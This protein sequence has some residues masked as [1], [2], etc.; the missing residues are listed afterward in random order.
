MR[1]MD[2]GRRKESRTFTERLLVLGLALS[3]QGRPLRPGPALGWA[4][5]TSPAPGI[6]T[7]EISEASGSL[8]KVLQVDI[9][10]PRF[11]FRAV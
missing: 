5:L 6:L 10:E 7:T 8:P 3:Q 1:C 4:V 11:K 9:W 2:D